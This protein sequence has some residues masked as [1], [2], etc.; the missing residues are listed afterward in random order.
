MP[1]FTTRPVKAGLPTLLEI[2]EATEPTESA[3]ERSLREL[4]LQRFKVVA[5]VSLADALVAIAEQMPELIEQRRELL[6]V[7]KGSGS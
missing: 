6:A 7:L 2:E 4:R 1:T 5:L 3:Y